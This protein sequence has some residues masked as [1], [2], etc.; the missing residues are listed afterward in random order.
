MTY[1]RNITDI[2]DKIIQRATENGEAIIELTDRFIRFMDEEPRRSASK[3]RTRSRARPSR[4][5]DAR[6]H[7][8]AGES[9]PSLSRGMTAM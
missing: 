2:E 7:R 8:R 3:R 9:R 6:H 5:A 4:S 1:V